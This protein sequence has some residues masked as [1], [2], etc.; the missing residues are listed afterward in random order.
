MR[1]FLFEI[2]RPL[3]VLALIGAT[4]LTVSDAGAKMVAFRSSLAPKVLS[5]GT[6]TFARSSENF[7][8]PNS[9]C[10]A[11]HVSQFEV[12]DGI[13]GIRVNADYCELAASS[14]PKEVRAVLARIQDIHARYAETLST[15]PGEL[16]GLGVRLSLAPH[17]I[18]PLASITSESPSTIEIDVF[19]DFTADRFPDRV[20]AHEVTHWL[21]LEQLL[22]DSALTIEGDYLFHESFPDLVSS[23][24]NDTPVVDFTDPSIRTDLTFPWRGKPISSMNGP[25]R[26]FYLGRFQSEPIEACA[27]TST[28]SMSTNEKKMCTFFST[29]SVRRADRKALFAGAVEKAPTTAELLTP[30]K[31]ERCLVHYKNGTAGLDACY[32]NSLGPVLI[33]FVRSVESLFGSK[34]IVTILSALEAAGKNPDHYTCA[35][36]DVRAKKKGMTTKESVSFIS[37]MQVLKLIRM[38]LLPSDVVVFDNAWVEHGLETWAT[39][40]HYDRDAGVA[41]FAYMHLAA[42][43]TKYSTTYKCNTPIPSE[44]GPHCKAR[45]TYEAAP[46]QPASE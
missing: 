4:G 36:T 26:D 12:Q 3:V 33:S 13:K 27:A 19:P 39:L 5:S 10:S 15:T 23:Y 43:N 31:P 22:G 37:F 18:G 41:A 25:L 29:D 42:E 2:M 45:C 16:F 44:R 7:S 35:F 1:R 32:M 40:D 14:L 38:Q 17:P 30:F 21:L 34:P 9:A 20:Y 24:V 46:P 6:Q 11:A 8:L 28:K